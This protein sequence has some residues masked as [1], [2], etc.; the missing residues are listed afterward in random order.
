MTYK[1][2]SRKRNN[3]CLENQEADGKEVKRGFQRQEVKNV[4]KISG[5]Q[6]ETNGQSEGKR[7][8]VKNEREEKK[9]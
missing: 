2:M 7:S 5:I 1:G 8:R 6:L 3:G 4:K 9:K